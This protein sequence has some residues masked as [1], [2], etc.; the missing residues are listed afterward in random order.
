VTQMR[1]VPL[2][3]RKG[4]SANCSSTGFRMIQSDRG[5]SYLKPEVSYEIANFN[6]L[7]NELSIKLQ[8]RYTYESLDTLTPSL[9]FRRCNESVDCAA[10]SFNIDVEPQNCF[11]YKKGLYGV[12]GEGYEFWLSFVKR[13]V[14]SPPLDVLVSLD[15]PIVTPTT[16]AEGLTTKVARRRQLYP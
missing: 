1:D 14:P 4:S 8:A 9:C 12:S 6:R 15:V 16:S 10:A 5:C 13:E 3:L 7:I 11:F 2:P